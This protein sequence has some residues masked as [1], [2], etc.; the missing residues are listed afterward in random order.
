[1]TLEVKCPTCQ[2]AVMWKSEN[3][4]RPFCSKRC[5]LIDLGQWA[6]EENK[7]ASESDVNDQKPSDID[8]EE[9]EALL[10]QQQDTFFKQ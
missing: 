8:I 6:N 10:A 3:E 9:I 2:K 4:H 7:I 5:Q 1:M